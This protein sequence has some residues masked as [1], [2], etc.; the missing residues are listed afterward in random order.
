MEEI[1]E[2]EFNN[3]SNAEKA[4]TIRKII[5]NLTKLVKEDK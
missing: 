1:T 4:K 2:K 3:L 5:Q